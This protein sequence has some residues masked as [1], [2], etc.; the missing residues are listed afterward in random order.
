M[1]NFRLYI[2][3]MILAVSLFACSKDKELRAPSCQQ[4]ETAVVNLDV[5]QARQAIESYIAN[6]PSQSYT[7]VNLE[8]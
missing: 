3:V 1:R 2:S 8:K 5:Q 7:E 4:L 6:L